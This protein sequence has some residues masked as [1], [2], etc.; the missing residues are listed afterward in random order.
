MM[1]LQLLARWRIMRA[2][3]QFVFWF[4][5]A[6]RPHAHALIVMCSFF[7]TDISRKVS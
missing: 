6:E 3:W 2:K 5:P 4:R 7:I 1:R